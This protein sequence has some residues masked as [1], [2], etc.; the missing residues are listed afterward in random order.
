MALI[1]FNKMVISTV[2]FN[3]LLGL[4]AMATTKQK[5]IFQFQGVYTFGLEGIW[6]KFEST[7][8]KMRRK[9]QLIS[10]RPQK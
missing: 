6:V 4:F 5:E 1:C 8:G 10:K 7:Y 9:L 3:A 2:F